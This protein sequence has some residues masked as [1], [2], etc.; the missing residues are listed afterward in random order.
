MDYYDNAAPPRHQSRET[1]SS[2][3]ALRSRS[4]DGQI[5]PPHQKIDITHVEAM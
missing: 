3:E 5:C 2:C 1:S 4:N